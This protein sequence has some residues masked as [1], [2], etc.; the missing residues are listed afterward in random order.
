MSRILLRL[1]EIAATVERDDL[2]VGAQAFIGV[3][4]IGQHLPVREFLLLLG[5]V[6]GVARARDFALVAV[7]DRQAGICRRRKPVFRSVDMRVVERAR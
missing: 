6:D 3:A 7:E 2:I 4:H 1:I 5:L